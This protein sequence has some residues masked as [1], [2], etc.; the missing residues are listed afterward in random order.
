[1][2]VLQIY[3]FRNMHIITWLRGSIDYVI[4]WSGARGART[5]TKVNKGVHG[6]VALAIK[7]DG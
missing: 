7:H 3:M 2:T 5:G 6:R 1:M 4:M